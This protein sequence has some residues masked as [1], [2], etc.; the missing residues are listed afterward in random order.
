VPRK[1]VVIAPLVGAHPVVAATCPPQVADEC[2]FRVS[3]FTAFGA[4]P[5]ASAD[6]LTPR[7]AA[8]HAALLG[9]ARLVLRP[10][11]K[12]KLRIRL[13][14]AGRRALRAGKR[15]HVRVLVSVRYNGHV[16]SFVVT[17]TLRAR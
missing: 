10:G 11:H 6:G 12:G 7:R 14:A 15:I 9:A 17:T 3:V 1:L 13:T 2:A 8:K 16:R 5:Q 4:V